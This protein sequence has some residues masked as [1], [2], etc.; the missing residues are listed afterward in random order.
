MMSLAT[1]IYNLQCE[2]DEAVSLVR[3]LVSVANGL[4][5][6][7]AMPDEYYIPA[8]DAAQQFLDKIDQKGGA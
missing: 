4:A 8:L 7:Q 3:E 6:Q 2:R 1:I 5:N